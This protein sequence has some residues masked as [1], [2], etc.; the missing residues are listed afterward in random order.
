MDAANLYEALD[1]SQ[2]ELWAITSDG[3][4]N[5]RSQGELRFYESEDDNYVGLR[6]PAGIAAGSSPSVVWDL[7]DSDG[8]NLDV[9]TT[10]GSGAMSFQQPGK[11]PYN[12]ISTNTT[13]DE[14][15]GAVEVDTSSGNVTITLPAASATTEGTTYTFWKTSASNNMIINGGGTNI[16]GASS[17]DYSDQYATVTVVATSSLWMKTAEIGT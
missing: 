8:N 9:L 1:S 2:N 10:D 13:I 17:A 14:S 3:T 4:M 11:R 6:A 15:Y 5:L 12:K 7:P 16:N